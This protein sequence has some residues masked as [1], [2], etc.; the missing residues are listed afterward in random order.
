MVVDYFIIINTDCLLDRFCLFISTTTMDPM[1]HQQVLFSAKRLI[2]CFRCEHTYRCH[3]LSIY[4]TMVTADLK[5][6]CVIT[7]NPW[8]SILRFLIIFITKRIPTCGADYI[9]WALE[10]CNLNLV[11]NDY[12]FGPPILLLNVIMQRTETAAANS[13]VCFQALGEQLAPKP[14]WFV[15]QSYVAITVMTTLNKA[16]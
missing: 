9:S 14:N 15:V 10:W 12:L 11:A 2:S 4:Q 16:S 7:H 5:I 3:S 6:A 13:L 8:I 1:L